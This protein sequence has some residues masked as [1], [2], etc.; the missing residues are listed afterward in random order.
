[1]FECCP[2]SRLFGMCQRVPSLQAELNITTNITSSL[3]SVC[4]WSKKV[5]PQNDSDP[6]HADIVLYITRC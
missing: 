2:S 5:N 1:M 6:Q 4:E 3:I